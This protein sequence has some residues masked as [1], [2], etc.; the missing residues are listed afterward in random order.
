MRFTVCIV[1]VSYNSAD[2]I[3]SCLNSVHASDPGNFSQIIVVDNDSSDH[4]VEVVERLFPSVMLIRSGANRG[5]AAAVNIGVRHSNSDFVLLLNPDTVVE[6]DAIR[7][8][9]EFAQ[10]EPQYGIYGGR[11]LKPDGTL[12]PSSCW[13]LPS[14]WSMFLF[15]FGITTLAPG[16]RWLDPESIGGWLRDTLKEVGV[17]TGC[18]LLVPRSVFDELGG[19]DERYFM[20]GEDVDFAIK[21]RAAG[22]RPVIC[23]DAVIIHEVGKSSAT[24][25]KKM[26]LLYRG[27]ACLVRTHWHGMARWSGL[28]L[29]WLGTCLRAASS[30]IGSR[31]NLISPRTHW[32]MLW[33]TR[34]QWIDGY[35]SPDHGARA[36]ANEVE[37][38]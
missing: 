26:L 11:T 35:P 31:L 16:N 29:L 1:I 18:F 25:G 13:G 19:L 32:E 27:K 22:Y 33:R 10:K 4:T 9:T 8:I 36:D 38:C 5:F 12:E 7:T 28:S 24:L 6:E 3:V 37:I 30:S 20:Y 14:L 15:A 21:A 23:P 2:N 17:V 34:K